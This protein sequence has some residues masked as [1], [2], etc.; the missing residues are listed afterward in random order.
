ST[1]A[2]AP[3]AVIRETPVNYSFRGGVSYDSEGDNRNINMVART[4]TNA[5]N[6]NVLPGLTNFAA[7][8]G[9]GNEINSGY[10]WST[11]LRSNLTV[12]DYG[13]FVDKIGNAIPYPQ[14]ETT[15][16]VHPANPDLN[17]RADTFFRGFDMDNADFY[18]YQEWLHDFQT[19]Y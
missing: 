13:V 15:Q 6:P 10:L 14:N 17:T 9:P 12:K 19:N 2:L 18:L 16:Q 3:D 5:S 11:A 1:G 8:D 4:G 7:P